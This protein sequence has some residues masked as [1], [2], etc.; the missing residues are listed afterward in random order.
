MEVV[1]KENF[2]Y[3][4]NNIKNEFKKITKAVS[5][6]KSLMKI[7]IGLVKEAKIY[8]KIILFYLI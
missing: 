8:L 4:F 6:I 2:F 1:V 7:K 3:N 5:L